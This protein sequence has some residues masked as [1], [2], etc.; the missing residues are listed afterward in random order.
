MCKHTIGNDPL[1][2]SPPVVLVIYGEVL[3]VSKTSC[4]EQ[5]EKKRENQ[6]VTLQQR[7]GL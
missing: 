6:W 2:F 5:E 4:D 7:Q 3:C 1:A